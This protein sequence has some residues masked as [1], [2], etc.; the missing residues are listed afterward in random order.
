MASAIA[1]PLNA[2]AEEFAGVEFPEGE[3]S[4]ADSVVS[5][6]YNDSQDVEAPHDDA[7][8]A[9][10]PPNYAMDDDQ[11]YVS[12]GNTAENDSAS[13]LILSFDDNRLV[14]RAGDDLYIFEVGPSVENTRVAISVDGTEWHDLGR[15][16]G[17]NRA[18]DLA[19]FNLPD[20]E[21]RYVRLNDF[22]DGNT[23]PA[24]YGG[25]DIDAVG[26]IGSVPGEDV[27]D[28]GCFQVT[29]ETIEYGGIDFPH[30]RVSFADQVVSFMPGAEVTGEN[31]DAARSLGEPDDDYVSL[32]VESDDTPAGVLTLFFKD[33]A[34]TDK[35][36]PDLY[37]FE[38]GPQT[39]ATFVSVS[40][41]GNEWKELGRVEG[42]TSTI[43]LAN[44]DV[45]ST[46][47][48][49]FVRLRTDPDEQKSRAPFG[50]P[51][52]DAVGAITSCDVTAD[53]DSD[54]DGT[55]DVVDECPFDPE[56]S[57]QSENPNSEDCSWPEGATTADQSINDLLEGCGC[58]AGPSSPVGGV[59]TLLVFGL[60]AWA[61]R[62][63]SKT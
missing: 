29:G 25:P 19:E 6:K 10:G 11:A 7:S 24:P 17:S 39:E 52:I 13:E 20:A 15:I 2:S 21:Y 42:S 49:R 56:R 46:A 18:L 4:F 28:E 53:T 31:L 43:D 26:A 12:L 14:D 27:P 38:T 48:Y 60:F 51:D 23:S 41:D 37:I 54:A 22:P 30:G 45:D 63:W 9:L 1:V 57:S 16:E 62:R 36:G 47:R 5:L 55:P 50:G 44:F 32:G 40:T 8:R 3:S 33:N 59:L 34:L 35:D 61:R 58:S